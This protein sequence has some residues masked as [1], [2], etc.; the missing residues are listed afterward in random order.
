MATVSAANSNAPARLWQV[1][2]FLV[3]LAA[4]LAVWQGWVPISARDPASAF[5]GDLAALR[6]ASEKLAPDRE[7]LK[8]LLDRTAKQAEA[9]PEHAPLAHFIIGSGYVRVAESTN[10]PTEALTFW[11]LARQH[12]EG[13]KASQLGDPLDPPRLAFRSAK[14]RAATLPAN[15]SAADVNLTRFFLANIPLGEP[16]G[17]AHRLNAELALR[18][19]PPDAVG[20]RTH[21][22][23]YVAEASLT[24]PPDSIARAK[25]RLSEVHL[26]LGEPEKARDWLEQIKDAPADVMLSRSAQL[27]RLLMSDGKWDKAAQEWSAVRNAKGVSPE[28]K[29][30]AAYYLGQ[31]YTRIEPADRVAAYT[32]FE[33]AARSE[34]PEGGAAA[35]RRAE[36]LLALDDAAKH[37]EAGQ[38]LVAAAARL[39][40]PA[41]YA[42]P[43]L[44]VNEAQATYELALQLLQ[45]DGTFETAAAVA[46]AYT[47]IATGDRAREK[48]AE[49]LSAWGESLKKDGGAFQQKLTAAADEYL[50]LAEEQ[51][52]TEGKADLLRRA[53]KLYRQAENPA[54]A[55]VAM[56]QVLKLP[57]LNDAT[58]GPV[59]L[60]YAEALVA[61][62]RP[63]EVIPAFNRAM[64]A[65]GPSSITARYKLARSLL[66][67]QNT[68]L[69]PL[70]LA[71]LEQAA[72]QTSV[73]PGDAM[74]HE[75]ALVELSLEYFRRGSFAEAESRLSVSLSRYPTGA[76]AGFA[77]LL[78]GTCLLQLAAT[79]RKP[80]DPEPEN[81]PQ[82]RADALALFER[83]V[84][85]IEQREKAGTASDRDRWLWT[86]ASLRICMTYL[87][88]N[89]TTE[90]LKAAA[91]VIQRCRGTVDELIALSII[92]HAQKLDDRK[93]LMLQTRDRMRELFEE[94]KNKPGAFRDK[95]GDYSREHW[96]TTWFSDPAKK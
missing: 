85:D 67:T 71:L 69:A 96:E 31:C 21:L 65:G 83:V 76:E 35:V 92:Y 11:H 15:T 73:G 1:P 28:L 36:L 26:L 94:L 41:G 33:E 55:V 13:V 63:E 46:D 2:T 38:I 37:A 77:R 51:M 49:L 80:E 48:R 10:N 52:R 12:F 79:K 43:L 17:D 57:D 14:A 27:A 47:S 70:G 9:Y 88:L 72:G 39:C 32:M 34:G 24:T 86:Q 44:P 42:N 23:A 78:K 50:K 74:T 40:G 3:G 62:K 66:D 68:Q 4:F 25:L 81:A 6:T 7:E 64:A 90:V 93:E 8:T 84:T 22:T 91:P 59:W 30:M 18:L 45:K 19:N 95:S 75:L 20:A 89:K 87:Q 29:S 60:D 5:L 16:P 58:L 82:L 53:A 56:E 54:A 61:A